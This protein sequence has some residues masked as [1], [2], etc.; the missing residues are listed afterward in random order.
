MIKKIEIQTCCKSHNHNQSN[1]NH[2][3]HRFNQINPMASESP[4]TLQS[5]KVLHEHVITLHDM[6]DASDCNVTGTI[7]GPLYNAQIE[8]KKIYLPGNIGQV[9]NF[10]GEIIIDDKIETIGINLGCRY[11]REDK[12]VSSFATVSLSSI[13]P[14]ASSWGYFRVLEEVPVKG[15][16]D[17]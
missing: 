12:T 7:K 10:E 14:Y 4:K 16:L 17:G 6:I 13:S 1:P 9:T 8:F 2:H 5:D 15:V 11:L 3:N